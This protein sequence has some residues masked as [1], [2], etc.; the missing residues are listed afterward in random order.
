MMKNI[1]NFLLV[2]AVFLFPVA[3]EAQ[4]H[5]GHNH[6]IHNQSIFP[7]K[8][9]RIEVQESFYRGLANNPLVAQDDVQALRRFFIKNLKTY[10]AMLRNFAQNPPN[11]NLAAITSYMPQIENTLIA[12]F[13]KAKRFEIFKNDFGDSNSS[14]AKGKGPNDKIPNGPCSNMGFENCDYTDWNLTQGEVNATAYGFINPGATTNWGNGSNIGSPSV[15]GSG[16]DQHFIVNAGVDPNAP[17]QM[18]NPLNGGTC[19][20]MIGDGNGTNYKASRISQQFLVDPSNADF[21]YSYAAVLEDPS[22]HTLGEKPY[23][24]AKV[25]DQAGNPI[26]C[27][28][29]QSTAGD[30]S[31]G[32][33]NTGTI[34][35]R[36]WS[37]VIVPLQAYIGQ[38]VTVEFTV[39]DCGQ[40][41]HYGYAYVESS[42]TPLEI[43]A[44]DTVVCGAPV[45]LNA[46]S[47]FNGTYLWSTGAT[48]ASITTSTPGLY[49]VD[50][51]TAPGCFI[52]L[53]V[54]ILADST[55]PTALFV[56]DTVCDGNATTFTDLSTTPVGVI[57]NWDW[58]FNNDGTIDNTTQNP[59]YIFS[60]PGVYPV[61]LAT[62]LGSCGHDTTINVYVNA[63]P[64]AD[65]SFTNECYGTSTQFADMSN[66]NGGTITSWQWDFDNNGTIDNSTQNPTNGFASAGTYTVELFIEAGGGCADS[67]SKLVVVHPVPVANFSTTTVCLGSS[68]AFTDLSNVATGNNVG[69]TWDFGDAAGSSN[70]QNP[71]YIYGGVGSY[72]ASLT[73]TSDSGCTNTIVLPVDVINNPVA[74]FSS[75]TVCVGNATSFNDLSTPN[76]NITAWQWDFDGNGTVDNTTPN[77]TNTFLSTGTYPVNLYV[78]V[79]SCSHDTTINVEVTATPTAAYT[80][81][82][83][84]FGTATGF[85]DLSVGNGGVITTWQWDFDNDGIV[86]NTSQN[87]NNGFPTAGTYT[88]ELYVS[89]GGACADSI[90]MQV[91]VNPIPAASFSTGNVCF[92]S[93]TTFN[94][95]S[96]ITTGTI[97]SWGW[98]F[99]DASG[100]SANQNP[101]YT[102]ASAGNYNVS[103][104]VIS[105]SGCMDVYVAPLDV[106]PEPTAAFATNDVCENVIAV[107]ADQSNANGGIITNW[108]WD[109]DNNGTV[110]NTNQ[111]PTNSYPS[112]GAY[113]VQLVVTT[114]SGCADTIV[115]PINIFPMPTAAYTFVN[116]CVG[117]AIA[118]TDNSSVSS[119]TIANWDWTFGNGNNS[120]IQ[121]PLENYLNEG[122]YNTE[123][124]VTSDNGCKD[125]LVQQVQ[126]WP[127]PVVDF[128]PTE[129][130]LYDTTQFNDLSFVSTASTPN[131][132]IQ[133]DWDFNGLGGS[134]LQNPSHIFINEGV[135]PTTLIVTTSNGCVDSATINVTVNPLP[136]INFGVDTSACAP[137]CVTLQNSSSISSGTIVSYQWDFGD[138]SGAGGQTPTY[139]FQNTSR[140]STKSYDVSLT[141]ISD[142]GCSTMGIE[143]NMVTVYPI[144]LA[145][146]IIEPEITDV[147]DKEISFYDNSEI[148]SS[149]Q[150]DLGDG[151]NSIINNPV[152]EYSDTGSYVISL[153]IENIFGCRDT[154]RREI[155][156]RP[157]YAIWIPNTF[158]PDGD[159]I[160]E[161][162]FVDGF[163]LKEVELRIFNRWGDQLFH[164]TGKNT[165]VIWDGEY[166]GSLVQDDVYVYK[167]RV[168]DVF[169]EYH[170][171][172]GRVTILK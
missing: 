105:D 24:M 143:T 16:G 85:T 119:G 155:R 167:A 170:D 47:P 160:N 27:G 109:F 80:F 164:Q 60:G 87:P 38:N 137:V 52:T 168:K 140:V 40:G 58:D 163:G 25:Y 122:L 115:Q 43:I 89:T 95:L 8:E 165:Q 48:S 91:V 124:I 50:L 72:N 76:N 53:D 73:V 59:S 79:G 135:V 96:V 63:L 149:W 70:L 77:P 98:D 156:I 117:T 7:N 37:T 44:S 127:L 11:T 126:V 30:G 17:I 65:F 32:W 4:N 108:D 33:V 29:F 88:T 90:T 14:S 102:Y 83:E 104:T 49:T 128:T 19:S 97:T 42:C 112:D 26:S 92:P 55:T 139:C 152:H 34:Q 121:N 15:L 71:G 64:V 147:Y 62:G 86:D 99:G 56:A 158:T 28:D 46:P 171:L 120:A 66:P 13:N 131:S 157:A 134:N 31:P 125:T 3:F 166:K 129:V 159:G 57:N 136:V 36:D 141:A 114:G 68:T 94:D 61:S 169:D 1:T 138:G 153:Y 113:N 74:N 123:L 21:S 103:L 100:T 69:W 22:G 18:V 107:F 148:A 54:T 82:N 35:Y 75:N 12:D 45:T 154:V 118:F 2:L 41:G 101:S 51:I 5:N 142:K 133:W 116:E 172:I 146:F 81:S 6:A 67:I 130:C 78:E 145:D 132:I 150:W 9:T 161:G 93:A 162:F 23:F 84:C 151:S 111:N 20:A 110:D 144:P 10:K 106:F 39:G